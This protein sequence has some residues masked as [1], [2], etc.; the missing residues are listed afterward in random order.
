MTKYT[1]TVGQDPD[2]RGGWKATLFESGAG[3]LH[4]VLNSKEANTTD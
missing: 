1:V 4:F 3:D 2:L